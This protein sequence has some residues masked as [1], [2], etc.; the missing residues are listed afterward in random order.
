MPRI[1]AAN[2]LS[3]SVLQAK[4]LP[5]L[6]S[7]PT[8]SDPKSGTTC[9][10]SLETSSS[11]SNPDLESCFGLVESTSSADYAS[12]SVGWSPAKK[13]REMRL[14]DLRYLLVRR[15]GSSEAAVQAFLSFMLTYEDGREV[16]YCYEIHVHA[17]MRGCGVGR[18]LMGMMEAVGQSVG[19]E[20]AMMTVFVVNEKALGFYG[21]LGYEEDEFSPKP[22]RLRGGV[23]KVP[24]YVILSKSL[25]PK[26]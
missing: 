1:E 25:M 11:I 12:S 15:T 6:T 2:A 20:K 13:R 14:P 24:D 5:T 16:V 10:I 19:V 7:H 21:A 22:R 26:D 23:V 9:T 3:L 18:Y 4:H 17:S 8:F